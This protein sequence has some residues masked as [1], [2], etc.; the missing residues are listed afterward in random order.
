MLSL[1]LHL[2][3]KST[4]CYN[5]LLFFIIF[6]AGHQPAADHILDPF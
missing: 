3:Q 5:S 1:Q 4:L 6:A 2:L